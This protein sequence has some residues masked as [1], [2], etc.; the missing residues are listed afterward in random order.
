ME[1]L[2]GGNRAEGGRHRAA[3]A[4]AQ[5]GRPA[6]RASESLVSPPGPSRLGD[7]DAAPDGV[8]GAH[9]HGALTDLSRPNDSGQFVA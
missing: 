7:D 6:L 4:A 3:P 1:T 8:A 5:A 9:W 2:R